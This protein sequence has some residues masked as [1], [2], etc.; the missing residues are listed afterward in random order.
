MS[1][2]MVMFIPSNHIIKQ[3]KSLQLWQM[4]KIKGGYDILGENIND[5]V[6]TM[7]KKLCM[8]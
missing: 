1:I 7:P 5:T 2:T 3:N 4:C 6:Q 8:P